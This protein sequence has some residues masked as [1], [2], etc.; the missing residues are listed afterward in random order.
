[1]RSTPVV[2]AIV[3]AALV[4][5]C[6][7]R[8]PLEQVVAAP[9]LSR[10][11]AWRAGIASDSSIAVRGR[12][13]E[14]FNEIRLSYAAERELK[15][16]LEQPIVRGSEAL[17]EAVRARV[18]G[19]RLRDVLKLGYELRVR[20]LKEEL[21]GLEDAMGKNAQLVTRPGDYESKQHLEGLRDRQSV[22]VQKYRDDLAAAEKELVSLRG[23]GAETVSNKR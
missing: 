8:D 9:T 5:G 10:L 18:N 19:K 7:P 17:D 4:A 16:Q 13:E 21:A 23:D 11:A 22:R 3:F 2:A 15:R 6:G 20:R 1:M 14:A 12:V